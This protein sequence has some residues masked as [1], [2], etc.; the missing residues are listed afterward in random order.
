MAEWRP[1]NR[2]GLYVRH[3]KRCRSHAGKRC[4]CEPSYRAKRRSLLTRQP[5]YSR[6]SKDRAAAVTWLEGG[7]KAT[8]AVQ[9]RRAAGPTFGELG[10][11]G[12]GGVANGSIAKRRGRR[13]LLAHHL[14]TLRPLARLHAVA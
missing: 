10:S 9:E 11:R 3:A 7:Q 6:T 12:R 14:A 13:P 4:N 1:T 2:K 8:E 5:E